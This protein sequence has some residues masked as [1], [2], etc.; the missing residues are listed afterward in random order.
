MPKKNRRIKK[1]KYLYSDIS[2][3]KLYSILEPHLDAS[4]S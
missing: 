2:K 1:V 4:I 3:K